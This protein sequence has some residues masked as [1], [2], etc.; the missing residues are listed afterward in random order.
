MNTDNNINLSELEVA[1]RSV[2]HN[3]HKF[4]PQN[5]LRSDLLWFKYQSLSNQRQTLGKASNVNAIVTISLC[6]SIFIDVSYNNKEVYLYIK[7]N[8]ISDSVLIL[9]LFSNLMSRR[10][11]KR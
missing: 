9:S 8:I 1:A 10:K 2:Y 11:R 5:C 7:E 4:S 6:S 3:S